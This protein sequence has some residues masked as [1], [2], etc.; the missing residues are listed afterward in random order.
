MLFFN[1]TGEDVAEAVS[2]GKLVDAG[3]EGAYAMDIEAVRYRATG[4]VLWHLRA[5]YGRIEESV[6]GPVPVSGGAEGQTAGGRA[7][8]LL[9][10]DRVD[11]GRQI[12]PVYLEGSRPAAER[13][14]LP[15]APTVPELAALAV[16]RDSIGAMGLP[17]L[18][19]LRERLA[20][21]G[22]PRGRLETEIVMK[23]FMPFAFL[24]L[25]FFALSF[26]WALRARYLGRPP[27]LAILF[28]PVVPIAAALASLLYVHGH[29]IV[30]GFTVLAFGLT[31]ALIVGAV[32][33]LAL[34][35]V[36]L[37][38]TPGQAA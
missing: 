30:L 21:F 19:R 8:L 11:R 5:R 16:G 31:A 15:L 14:I 9:S 38:L 32:L 13:N 12:G 23:A 4:E 25:A 24:V 26:G 36:A 28:V 2:I 10:V 29:R 18:W 22:M 35:F 20:S 6:A 37:V 34:L 27:L 3:R 33:S 7:I 1:G 17:E